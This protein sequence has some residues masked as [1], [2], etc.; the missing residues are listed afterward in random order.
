M[1]YAIARLA[2]HTNERVLHPAA[3]L[4]YRARLREL[5]AAGSS[6]EAALLWARLPRSS[7]LHHPLQMYLTSCRQ[8]SLRSVSCL[9]WTEDVS[10]A[11]R[12]GG[13]QFPLIGIFSR[14]SVVVAPGTSPSAAWEHYHGHAATL[15]GMQVLGLASGL[16]P[17]DLL[18][19]HA[20]RVVQHVRRR[21]RH[22]RGVTPEQLWKLW[23][24]GHQGQRV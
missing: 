22:A 5:V 1:E 9:A 4:D 20:N 16:W 23:R 8:V 3:M 15:S 21:R 18:P 13:Y 11:G 19:D 14:R 7:M 12:S 6:Y 24:S 2:V 10:V 17:T